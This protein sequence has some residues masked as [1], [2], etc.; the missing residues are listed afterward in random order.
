ML[1]PSLCCCDLTLIPMRSYNPNTV[2]E[3]RKELTFLELHRGKF[4]LLKGQRNFPVTTIGIVQKQSF[5]L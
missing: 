2:G 3:G 4:S 1:T 5:N